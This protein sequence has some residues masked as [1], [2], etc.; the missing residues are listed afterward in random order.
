MGEELT[1]TV[2]SSAE[3][4][5]EAV[6]QEVA[7]ADPQGIVTAV[8]SAEE[9]IVQQ[10]SG[11]I[12]WAK[13]FLTWN[14]LFKVIGAVIVLLVLW[15]AYKLILKTLKKIPEEKMNAHRQMLVTRIVKYVF[16]V[17]VIMYVCRLFGI[18]LNAIWGAA[19]IAGVAIGF[20]AQT[21]VSNIIS[22]LFVITEGTLKIGDL[23]T[24]DDITGYVE[25][26]TLLSVRVHTFDNQMVRVPNSSIINNNLINHTFHKDRRMT[27]LVSIAYESD[28]KKALEA[29]AKAPALC[30]TVLKKPEGEIWYD[31]FGESS[32]NLVVAVYYKPK[33]Y[34]KTRNDMF[35]AIKQVLDEAEISIPFNQLDVKIK[36]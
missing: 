28:M 31:G 2:V 35:I 10:T 16:Y 6:T 29:L 27:F 32:I 34:Y 21:S 33:D 14:N 22:G 13:T 1:E 12:T 30:P 18:N 17:I 9:S 4:I 36:E 7:A 15:L 8:S 24:V 25:S 19:G 3:G 20:A 23:I 5:T 26:I 11:F